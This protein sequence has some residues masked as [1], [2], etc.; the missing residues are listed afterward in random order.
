MENVTAIAEP[1]VKVRP[2]KAF[3]GSYRCSVAEADVI[4]DILAEDE[5]GNVVKRKSPR[6]RVIGLVAERRAL[7]AHEI[8]AALKGEL[9]DRIVLDDPRQLE[10]VK[11]GASTIPI[12]PA[13]IRP[14][15]EFVEVPASMADDLVARGL[16]E[17]VK[18]SRV[19]A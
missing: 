1:R 15:V 9:L 6:K 14:S 4:D 19:R 13:T 17:L 7:R 2:L 12:I 3:V 16:A 10:E 18:G 8:E 5:Q 11:P